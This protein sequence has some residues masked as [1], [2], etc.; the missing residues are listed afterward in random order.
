LG[1]TVGFH[2]PELVIGAPEVDPA[3]HD[4]G[5]RRSSIVAGVRLLGAVVEDFP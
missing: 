4:E 3:V 1:G 5:R 2:P